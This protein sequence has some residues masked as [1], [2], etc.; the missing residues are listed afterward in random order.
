VSRLLSPSP[1]VE[2]DVVRA[3][4]DAVDLALRD[5]SRLPTRLGG[6]TGRGSPFRRPKPS[7]SPTLSP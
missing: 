4:V 2:F 7:R 5:R 3:G 6:T 1:V